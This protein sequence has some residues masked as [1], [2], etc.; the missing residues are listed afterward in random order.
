MDILKVNFL[1]GRK[2]GTK[3]WRIPGTN[4]KQIEKMVHLD[5]NTPIITSNV[6]NLNTQRHRLSDWI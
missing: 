4:R 5:P 1:K 2:R 3:K 6:N